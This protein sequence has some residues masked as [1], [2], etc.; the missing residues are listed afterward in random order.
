MIL[1]LADLVLLDNLDM[2]D[3]GIPNLEWPCAAAATDIQDWRVLFL[4]RPQH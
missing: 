3:L 1:D 2:L 4:P